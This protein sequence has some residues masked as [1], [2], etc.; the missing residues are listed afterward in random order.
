MLEVLPDI[1]NE[2]P[3]IGA[4]SHRAVYELPNNKVLKVPLMYNTDNGIE[5]GRPDPNDPPSS[6]QNKSELEVYQKCPDG[7]KYLLCPI[8]HSFG[9]GQYTFLIMEKAISFSFEYTLELMRKRPQCNHEELILFYLREHFPESVASIY[10]DTLRL[11]SLLE[12]NSVDLMNQP[13]NWGKLNGRL[14]YIDY[15]LVGV[16]LPRC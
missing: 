3:L 10:N 5:P 9:I 12:L 16:K 15:G 2:L 13:K 11:E 14:V 4:G 8:V 6:N 1:L 7:L